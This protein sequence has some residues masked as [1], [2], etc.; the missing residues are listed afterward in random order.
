[1]VVRGAIKVCSLL[2]MK[3]SFKWNGMLLL[4]VGM[5][6][7]DGDCIRNELGSV[8]ILCCG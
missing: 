4:W 7:S 1:M 3:V 8:D 5:G 6:E 2:A